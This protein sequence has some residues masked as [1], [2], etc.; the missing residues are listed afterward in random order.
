M[1]QSILAEGLDV[2]GM[3]KQLNQRYSRAKHTPCR[4]YRNSSALTVHKTSLVL[5]VLPPPVKIIFV[6]NRT[7]ILKP[8][9]HR[10]FF[11]ASKSFMKLSEYSCAVTPPIRQ[12]GNR[13]S[14]IAGTAYASLL[15]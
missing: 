1:I 8:L 9:E 15:A 2:I 3:V 10:M 5:F 6:R 14:G 12:T 13:L 4:N 11:K 7:R